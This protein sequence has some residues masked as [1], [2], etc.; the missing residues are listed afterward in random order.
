MTQY[1]DSKSHNNDNNVNLKQA[2]SRK[3]Y[4]NSPSI[5][6]LWRTL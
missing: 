2:Q 6:E 3:N 1:L 4:R 5:S